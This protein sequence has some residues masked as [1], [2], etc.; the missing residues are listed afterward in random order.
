MGWKSS[1]WHFEG[2]TGFRSSQFFLL[3][4]VS[5]LYGLFF[6]FCY[7]HH[8]YYCCC[9]CCHDYFLFQTC[10]RVSLG[11]HPPVPSHLPIVVGK[12]EL[13]DCLLTFATIIKFSISFF[14]IFIHN[15]FFLARHLNKFQSINFISE[16]L[17]PPLIFLVP[18]LC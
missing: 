8:Y 15:R 12:G 3:A 17:T 4:V 18:I 11:F 7:Y 13:A 6:F 1:R 16:N 5:Q 2:K 10:V 9:Y 14:Y